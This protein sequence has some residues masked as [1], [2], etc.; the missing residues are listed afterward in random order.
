MSAQ[1]TTSEASKQ[2][3][4]SGLKY[5]PSRIAEYARAGEFPGAVKDSK[6]NWR[7][8]EQDLRLFIKKQRRRKLFR[9]VTLS[10]IATF[11]AILGIISVTKDGLDLVTQYFPSQATTSQTTTALVSG[12]PSTDPSGSDAPV[13]TLEPPPLRQQPPPEFTDMIPPSNGDLLLPADMSTITC[14][15]PVKLEWDKGSDN[16]RASIVYTWMV[17]KWNGS[18]YDLYT[19]G[20]T[21]DNYVLVS[22]LPCNTWYG[23]YVH[24]VDRSGN[25]SNSYDYRFFVS[26]E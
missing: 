23:W 2:L 19:K 22:S 5:S 9:G 26:P 11:V 21:T 8:P 12:T 18:G 14:N 20:Q 3:R 4:A 17:D 25:S 15:Q 16:Q 6:N 24:I 7:I 1:L 10:S 13:T